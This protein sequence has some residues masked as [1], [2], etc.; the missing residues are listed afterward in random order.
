MYGITYFTS[1]LKFLH[2]Q[3]KYNKLFYFIKENNELSSLKG[4]DLTS[5]EL[6]SKTIFPADNTRLYLLSL[7][8]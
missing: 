2:T 1:F 5:T 7:L 3:N 4:L 8:L 6:R